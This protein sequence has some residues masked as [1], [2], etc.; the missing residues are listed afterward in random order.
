MSEEQSTKKEN[1]IQ[2]ETQESNNNKEE[3]KDNIKKEEEKEKENIKKELILPLKDQGFIPLEDF[4]CCK[5]FYYSYIKKLFLL[6]FLI[7]SIIAGIITIL[8]EI[9][10]I[11]TEDFVARNLGKIDLKTKASPGIISIGVIKIDFWESNSDKIIISNYGNFQ[12][13][14]RV[15][16]HPGVKLVIYP[17]AQL[18]FGKRVL[19]GCQTKLICCKKMI[20][21]NDIR[22]SWNCQVFD[23]DF[24][25]LINKRTGK[26][27]ERTKPVYLGNNVFIGNSSTIGKG[28]HLPD[29]CIVSCCTKIMNDFSDV[30]ESALIMG[31]PAKV[32]ASGYEITSGWFPEKE[33]E[34]SK[35]V[36]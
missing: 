18:I 8:C 25:F 28:T 20:L 10:M 33:I 13:G 9:I 32:V 11:F 7:I 3:E 19:L 15:K 24:H 23:S 16:I 30:G 26:I 34:I 14:G 5:I 1:A 12:I 22:I 27:H 35:I 6:I 36:E 21:G 2:K 4:S 29:G 17:H 31:T